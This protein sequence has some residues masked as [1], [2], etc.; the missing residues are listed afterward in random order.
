MIYIKRWLDY[1]EELFPIEPNQIEFLQGLCNKFPSPAKFLSVEAG[2]ALLSRKMAEAN[3]EVTITDTYTEFISLLHSHQT[4][5]TNKIHAFNLPP[6]DIVRYLGKNF[7]NLI[8]CGDYRLIFIKDKAQVQKLLFDSKMLL[9]D[10]GYIVLDLINFAKYDF[11]GPRIDLAVQKSDRVELYSHILK[12]ASTL[13]YTLNQQ[14]VTKDGQ[15]IDEVKNEPTTPISLETFKRTAEIAKFSSIEFY[16]D[17]Y[18]H[19]LEED[20]DKIICVL[21]K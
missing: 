14:V 10:G 11:S 4:E 17:Y 21:K 20:S 3:N 13:K 5:I 18:G 7:Y 16:S 12:D 1:Y 6:M 19:P 8:Y 9:S 15:S 2:T